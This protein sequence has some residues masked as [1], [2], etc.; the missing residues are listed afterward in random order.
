MGGVHAQG[1]AGFASANLVAVCDPRLEAAQALANVH[2][3]AA[4]TDV[5][6]ML[7]EVKPDVVDV[8]VPTPYHCETVCRLASAGLKGIIVEKPMARSV[9]ECE[10]MTAACA[11]SGTRLFVAHVLRFFPEFVT[12][13]TQVLSG[14][15]GRPCAV[16]TKRGGAFPRGWDDWYGDLGRSGGLVLDLIIH[17]F[18]WLRWTFGEVDRVFA[19]GASHGSANGSVGMDYALVTLRFQSGVIAHV[20]GTWA[21]PSGFKVAFEIAGDNGMLE[22]NFNQP[23]SQPLTTARK[24]PPG[25]PAAVAVP[26]NPTAAS[27][28]QLELEHFADCILNGAE[29][30]ITPQ[31]GLEAVRIAIAACE[32]MRTGS[33]VLVK[34]AAR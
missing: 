21:D 13:R 31:D 34:G 11:E 30:R 27:P 28:Y 16:R 4:Y 9:E 1:Y 24:Q 12:A 3:A 23:A 15:V 14:A 6:T 29:P 8:C 10:R 22:Y 32:S 26:E 5:D 25:A 2:N 7:S 17:D 33:P 20:E 18:D 19:R